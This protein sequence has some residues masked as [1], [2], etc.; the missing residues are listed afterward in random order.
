MAGHSLSFPI[1]MLATTRFSAAFRLTNFLS[2]V[3]SASSSSY[4]AGETQFVGPARSDD[5]PSARVSSAQRRV[6]LCND[7]QANDPRPDSVQCKACG[8][9]IALEGDG[10]YNLSSW[11]QH[12]SICSFTRYAL[13]FF[14]IC[15]F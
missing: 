10:E 15:S 13:P 4:D 7:K 1:V 8:G 3:D 6:Y 14:Y 12:K 9:R 5:R 2:F 11:Q